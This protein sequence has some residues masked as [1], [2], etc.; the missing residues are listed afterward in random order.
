MFCL[1]NATTFGA[2]LRKYSED[3]YRVRKFSSSVSAG[4]ATG[5]SSVTWDSFDSWEKRHSSLDPNCSG[6]HICQWTSALCWSEIPYSPGNS[7]NYSQHYANCSG[8][9]FLQNKKGLHN[10]CYTVFQISNTAHRLNR[11]WQRKQIARIHTDKHTRTYPAELRTITNHITWQQ[12]KDTFSWPCLFLQH[13][14]QEQGGQT[15][16]NMWQPL[17]TLPNAMWEALRCSQEVCRR[18]CTKEICYANL[19]LFYTC[20]QDCLTGMHS[21]H[22]VP[23]YVCMNDTV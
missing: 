1:P 12:V 22:S 20:M 4:Y 10:E 13:T 19:T 14:N 16:V 17:V 18:I 15:R 21:M 11:V 9:I 2:L 6:W 5:H 23:R 8:H 7:E 3:W